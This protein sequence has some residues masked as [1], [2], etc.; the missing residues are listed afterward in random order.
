MSETRWQHARHEIA[1][2]LRW[3]VVYA[4][5]ALLTWAAPGDDAAATDL[6]R[7]TQ[8]WQARWRRYLHWRFPRVFAETKPE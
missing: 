8:L 3:A 1:T 2:L 6:V 4:A 5:L 7:Q